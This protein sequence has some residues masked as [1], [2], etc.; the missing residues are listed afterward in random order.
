MSQRNV[1]FAIAV[2]FLTFGLVTASPS[3]VLAATGDIS[4]VAGGGINEGAPASNAGTLWPWSVFLDSSGNIY[5]SD[6][7]GSRIQKI[8]AAT[9]I[10]NTIVGNGLSGRV[11]GDAGAGLP[12]DQL[13]ISG[14]AYNAA[15]SQGN[16]Y[17]RF[18]GGI[19]KADP[20]GNVTFVTN[21][22]TPM[23]VD[24]NDNFYYRDGGTVQKIDAATGVKS[25]IVGSQPLSGPN[26][27]STDAAG[28]LYF[29]NQ[30]QHQAFKITP[31]GSVT[32]FAGDGAR[33][34]DNGD[35][36]FAGD[37]GTA[38]LASLNRAMSTTVDANGNVYIADIDNA[39]IRRVDG[40]TGIIS[41]VVGNGTQTIP[42][43]ETGGETYMGG[44]GGQGTD[45]MLGAEV[46][47]EVDDTGNLYIA[48]T[49]NGRIRKLDVASGIITTIAGGPQRL[50]GPQGLYIDGA[51]NVF[52][53]DTYNNRILKIDASGNVSV[54]AGNGN[55]DYSGDGG[56]ATDAGINGPA[57]VAVSSTGEIFIVDQGNQ[58][59]RR[60]DSS[61]II[62]TVA[63][64]NTQGFSGDDGP[65]TSAA[66]NNP[67]AVDLNASGD[68]F[69]ADQGNSRIRKVAVATGVISTIAGGGTSQ[70]DT[71]ALE[72]ELSQPTDVFIDDAG[73]VFIGEA[74]GVSKRV[75][76]IDGS[77]NL[78]TVA[79]TGESGF[80]GDGG[81]AT[82]AT[83]SEASRIHVTASGDIYIWDS[84]NHRAR[85][86]DAATGII[87]TVVGNGNPGFTG[88]G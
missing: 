12:A 65:A 9:G 87:T 3:S 28:N 43:W 38:I 1:I 45:A 20:S 51:G 40:T 84:A 16:V 37:G 41:T 69:I 80:S 56:P 68:I 42:P 24:D 32:L 62:T 15:D 63:G 78:V 49:F 53:A 83:I 13:T 74:A 10:M 25:F 27:L 70:A 44:D 18:Q 67:W 5:I 8:D 81:L 14:P 11:I 86:V 71:L 76:K 66:I 19:H 60:V 59:I 50:S 21:G 77:G 17:F 46:Y 58:V 82:D 29:V 85:K 7:G 22:T 52:L 39:R 6:W 31:S 73:T 23:A 72:V 75:R 35:G 36:Q 57:D 88:D 4:T 30:W 48:D 61:G 54:V 34:G 33:V 2:A 64:N 26:G 55:N 47:L 79:G